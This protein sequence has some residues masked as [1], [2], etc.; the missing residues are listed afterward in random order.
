MVKYFSVT[1]CAW[2]VLAR[3]IQRRYNGYAAHKQQ[4][5]RSEA[6]AAPPRR[7]TTPRSVIASFTVSLQLSACRFLSLRASIWKFARAKAPT[8]A[9][10]YQLHTVQIGF[11]PNVLTRLRRD[12][13]AT[14]TFRCRN[15]TMFVVNP[16]RWATK[17]LLPTKKRLKKLITLLKRPK[18]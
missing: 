7:K 11:T 12:K 17:F 1:G 18:E 14:S 8:C 15:L 3:A 9:F 5:P 2:S 13:S 16:C 6:F 4:K 10:G